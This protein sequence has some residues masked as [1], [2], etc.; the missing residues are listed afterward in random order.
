MAA[1]SSWTVPAMAMNLLRLISRS[2]RT[3]PTSAVY[4]EGEDDAEE[5]D[6]SRTEDAAELR[7]EQLWWTGP[8]SRRGMERRRGRKGEIPPEFTII[9]ELAR[10]I[11]HLTEDVIYTPASKPS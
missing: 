6:M 2:Q 9:G 1:R 8:G 11:H 4:G 5:D 7:Q 10:Q 3:R